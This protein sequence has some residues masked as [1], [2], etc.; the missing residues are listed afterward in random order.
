MKSNL[1]D[2][3]F[4][5]HIILNHK[6]ESVL[7]D[8]YTQIPKMAEIILGRAIKIAQKKE[9]KKREA[10]KSLL[11]KDYYCEKCRIGIISATLNNRWLLRVDQ[12]LIS[13]EHMEEK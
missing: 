3:D 12:F 4:I 1:P 2:S 11:K 9:D 6:D 10:R 5:F 7:M 8:E 13:H